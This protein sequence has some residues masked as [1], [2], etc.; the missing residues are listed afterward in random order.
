[1]Q[2][3]IDL[4]AEKVIEEINRSAELFESTLDSMAKKEYLSLVKKAQLWFKN[5]FIKNLRLHAI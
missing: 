3:G 2:K 4:Y 1:M 5:N